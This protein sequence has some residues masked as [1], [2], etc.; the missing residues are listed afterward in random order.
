MG[1]P[2]NSMEKRKYSQP[3]MLPRKQN[4]EMMVFMG[5]HGKICKK[6]SCKKSYK[7]IIFKN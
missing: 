7:C 1:N 2:W 3:Q 6:V 5:F 4:L